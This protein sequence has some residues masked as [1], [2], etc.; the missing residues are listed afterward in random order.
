MM[1]TVRETLSPLILLLSLA[2][3][4][5]CNAGLTQSEAS[6]ITPEQRLFKLQ[7]EINVVLEAAVAYAEQPRCLARALAYVGCHDPSVVRQMA[8]LNSE[9][10][11]L[12]T[13]ARAG[14]VTHSTVQATA[15]LVRRLL[16]EINTKLLEAKMREG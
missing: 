4:S 8:S 6:Q 12:M 9:I 10:G 7:G 2:L 11:A 14:D 3:L 13:S 1:I 16:A 5:G 15:T